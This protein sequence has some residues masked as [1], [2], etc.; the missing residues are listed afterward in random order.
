MR[1]ILN[2]ERLKDF[3]IRMRTRQIH[4]PSPLLFNTV[5]EVLAISVRQENGI[6]DVKTGK[7]EIKYSMC[8][9]II[10]SFKKNQKSIKNG[11]IN[12]KIQKSCRT[13][14]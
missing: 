9:D 14:D 1:V 7:E 11:R 2:G 6:N 12:R 13:Q 10:V 4:P 8:N 3:T 5:P